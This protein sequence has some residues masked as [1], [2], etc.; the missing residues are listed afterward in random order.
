MGVT[1]GGSRV[2]PA[3][4][5]PFSFHLVYCPCRRTPNPNLGLFRVLVAD[6]K[7]HWLADHEVQGSIPAQNFWVFFLRGLPNPNP[8][9]DF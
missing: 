1:G 5:Y 7:S 8:T 4:S 6:I 3:L 9:V 2:Q